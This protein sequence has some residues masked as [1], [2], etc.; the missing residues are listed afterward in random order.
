MVNPKEMMEQS[1]QTFFGVPV[2]AVKISKQHIQELRKR[3]NAVLGGDE[4]RFR[5]V[6]SSPDG[7]AWIHMPP[8]AAA[9]LEDGSLKEFLEEHSGEFHFGVRRKRPRKYSARKNGKSM[10]NSPPAGKR[11]EGDVDKSKF[12]FVELFAG[13]GGFRL[14]LEAI[15]GRCVMSSEMNAAA[16]NIFRQHFDDGDEEI[17]IEGD[18]LDVANNDFADEFTMLTGGFPCQPF[19]T[20]GNQGGLH[21][22]RGQLYQELVRVLTVKQPACFMFENVA[23]LVTLNGGKRGRREKEGVETEFA[24]GGVFET[25]LQAFRNCGYDVHW[26]IVNARHFVPQYRERV[27]IVGTRCSLNK[28]HHRAAFPWE[29]VMNHNPRSKWLKLR[30]ILEAKESEAVSY[31]ILNASQWEKVKSVHSKK[32]ST[33]FADGRLDLDDLAPTLISQYHRV[34]SFSTKFVFEEADGTIRDG[35]NGNPLPRFL[36]P[37]E[38]CRIMGF[39]ESYKVPS[40]NNSVECAHFYHAIGNA[41]VPQVIS[42]IG[43]ELLAL[44][45]PGLS[46]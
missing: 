37:R 43:K 41:V 2:G 10:S 27:Y 9:A 30:S 24:T 13:I 23:G 1:K 34:G 15:G 5:A 18:I 19:S 20:R 46:K 25:I 39:P 12:T 16:A 11:Q 4:I 31:S 3:L 33:A 28:D 40:P 7:D 14:G 22:D 17:L 45:G 6:E 21:D 42:S 38:C 35:E 36:T 29:R 32:G 44:L 8:D 26:K